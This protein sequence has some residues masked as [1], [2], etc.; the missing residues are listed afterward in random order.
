MK[1]FV[2]SDHCSYLCV[3]QAKSVAEARKILLEQIGTSDGS[4]P[5]RTRAV[6]RIVET[7][8][9]IWVGANCDIAIEESPEFGGDPSMGRNCYFS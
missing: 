8:P 3:A 7:T 1:M 2:W 9:A 4:C 6:R 5:N